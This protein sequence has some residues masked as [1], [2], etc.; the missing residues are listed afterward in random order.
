MPSPPLVSVVVATHNRAARLSRLLGALRKQ[1]LDAGRYEVIVVDDASSDAT[2]AVLSREQSRGELRLRVIRRRQSAGPAT[3]R[4]EGWRAAEGAIIA[5]TDD[6]CEPDPTWLEA[7]LRACAAKQAGFVQGRTIP[8]PAETGRIGPFTRTIYVEQLDLN[9]HTCNI[10]YPRELLERIGGFDVASYGRSPGGEDCDLAWRAIE[11]GASPT[12]CSDAIVHHA[13]NE[14]GPV[15]K[16]RV[17]ARWTNPMR[18][19][20]SHPQLRKRTF[21]FG[22]FWKRDHYYLARALLTPAVPRRWWP[23]R[24]WLLYPYARL[25][26]ARGRVLGGGL[27]LA[28]YYLLHDLVEAWSVVRAAV[29]YRTPMF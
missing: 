6:D 20:A 1:A 8:I 9:F 3:A 18:A 5:F 10:L 15:G 12:F 11:A 28:P 13:V 24:A 23:L 4:D 2:P 26:W 21:L 22:V 16:L 25:L 27:L 19:Y 29:R 7:G 17:A 14:L